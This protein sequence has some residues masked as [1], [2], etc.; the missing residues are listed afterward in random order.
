MFATNAKRQ[1]HGAQGSMAIKIPTIEDIKTEAHNLG[2]TL[3]EV[4]ELAEVHPN[5]IFYW[6]HGRKPSVRILEKLINGLEIA[7]NVN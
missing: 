3:A 2:F 4:C 6:N 7:K 5:N 1:I